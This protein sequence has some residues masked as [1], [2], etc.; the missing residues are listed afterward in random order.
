MLQKLMISFKLLAI[1]YVYFIIFHSSLTRTRQRWCH[2]VYIIKVMVIIT[3]HNSVIHVVKL[4]QALIGTTAIND[5][6]C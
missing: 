4:L 2:L 5:F 6:Y 3:N 1:V